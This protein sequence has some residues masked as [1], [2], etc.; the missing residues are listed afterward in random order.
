MDIILKLKTFWHFIYAKIRGKNKNMKAPTPINIIAYIDLLA[1]SNFVRENVEDSL[2]VFSGYNEILKTKIIDNKIQS[3]G[4]EP[5]LILRDLIRRTS[6]SSFNYFLPFSDSIFLASSD[7]NL[8]IKQLG[9]FVLSC[10]LYN[11]TAYE[12]DTFNPQ[13]PY[14]QK[15]L[16]LDRSEKECSIYPILFRGGIC[17]GNVREGS[18]IGIIRDSKQQ[19]PILVGTP[20]VNA[21]KMEGIV[22]GPRLIIDKSSYESLNPSTKAYIQETE[23]KDYFEILWP[24]FHYIKENGMSEISKFHELF[25]PAFNLWN[26]FNHT[27]HAIHYFSLLKLITK[28]TLVFFEQMGNREDAQNYIEQEL[29]KFNISSKKEILLND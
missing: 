17:I 14:I 22:K 5:N 18:V 19:M 26:A 29:N 2:S 6:M 21:V 16:C 11:A 1:M 28:S 20:V 4:A 7:A 24:A 23:T 12:S 9:H 8:F 27:E 13:K 10:Y 15:L 3:A 25:E